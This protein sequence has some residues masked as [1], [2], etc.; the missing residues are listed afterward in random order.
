MGFFKHFFRDGPRKKNA[1][2]EFWRTPVAMKK[3][4]EVELG[5]QSQRVSRSSRILSKFSKDSSNKSTDKGQDLNVFTLGSVSFGLSFSTSVTF[6]ILIPNIISLC[7]IHVHSLSLIVHLFPQLFTCNTFLL[8]TIS[9]S[10]FTR[11]YSL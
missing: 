8:T 10:A 9:C 5:T 1:P 6:Y 4:L 3:Q 2:G 7:N 11:Y